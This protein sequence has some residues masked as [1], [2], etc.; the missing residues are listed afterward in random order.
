M[1]ASYERKCEY[2]GEGR[3][4]KYWAGLGCWI[5]PCYSLLSLGACFETNELFISLIF[6]I[7][8]GALGT[9]SVDEGAHRY[10][11][12]KYSPASWC[13]IQQRGNTQW[14]LFFWDIMIRQWA[15]RWH[16][17]PWTWY[18]VVW[19]CQDQIFQAHSLLFLQNEVLSYLKT[20]TC[21]KEIRQTGLKHVVFVKYS[22]AP[23]STGNT[24]FTHV[25]CTP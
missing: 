22:I 5:S 3:W 13:T 8:W 10:F 4:V 7:F 18:Y 25:I 11:Y 20:H 6:K 19:E 17:D 1:V 12:V 15:I 23:I 21:G 16:F 24:I 2:G 9:D 14:I